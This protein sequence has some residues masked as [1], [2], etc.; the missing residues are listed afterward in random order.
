MKRLAGYWYI[1]RF[2]KI[3]NYTFIINTKIRAIRAYPKTFYQQ[4]AH[5][6]IVSH[7][8]CDEHQ[9][10]TRRFLLHGATNKLPNGDDK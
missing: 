9:H 10:T 8:F 2:T 5:V 3:S 7:L 6:I 1:I 4:E